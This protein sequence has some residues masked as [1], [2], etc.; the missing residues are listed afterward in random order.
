MKRKIEISLIVG[1]I[2]TS[3]LIIFF[4]SNAITQENTEL[5]KTADSQQICVDEWAEANGYADNHIG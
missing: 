5:P 1:I 2:L 3:F 4:S